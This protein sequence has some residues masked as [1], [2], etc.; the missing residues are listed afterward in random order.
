MLTRNEVYIQLIVELHYVL[1]IQIL[2]HCFFR[3]FKLTQYLLPTEEFSL[4]SISVIL[5]LGLLMFLII[6]LNVLI[7]FSFL[8]EDI[9]NP[10]R[11]VMWGGNIKLNFEL[12]NS[13]SLSCKFRINLFNFSSG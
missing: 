7:I 5:I 13:P 12:V 3:T 2:I 4:N 10:L 8:S 6:F 1:E 9:Y 11:I